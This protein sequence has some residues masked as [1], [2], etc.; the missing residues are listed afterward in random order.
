MSNSGGTF[1]YPDGDLDPNELVTNDAAGGETVINTG[2]YGGPEGS[3]GLEEEPYAATNDLE[4]EPIDL[5][6][7]D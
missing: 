7:T 5:D 4:N 3:E 1:D 2:H 6:E